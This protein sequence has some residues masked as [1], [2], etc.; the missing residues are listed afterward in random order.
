MKKSIKEIEDRTD[1]LRESLESYQEKVRDQKEI[2]QQI[3]QN[4]EMMKGKNTELGQVEREMSL[5][6]LTCGLFEKKEKFSQL[7][8]TYQRVLQKI[9]NNS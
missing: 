2:N 9:E 4:L 1:E 5:Q 7:K 8:N 3:I 6:E